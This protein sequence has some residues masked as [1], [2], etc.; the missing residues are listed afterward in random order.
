MESFFHHDKAS[1]YCVKCA[2]EYCQKL[3]PLLEHDSQRRRKNPP[4]FRIRCPFCDVSTVY[5]E[6][7]IVVDFV[8]RPK[9]FVAT[10]GF[11]NVRYL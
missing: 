7:E 2:N 11:R 6:N 9:S 10:E 1:F 8:R 5:S 3:I 4:E